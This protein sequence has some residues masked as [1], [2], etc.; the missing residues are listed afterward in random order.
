LVKKV[1]LTVLDPICPVDTEGEVGFEQLVLR[2][3]IQAKC[4]SEQRSGLASRF[5]GSYLLRASSDI[6]FRK[7]D[8][9]RVGLSFRT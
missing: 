7:Y 9:K 1:T 2:K 4:S 6:P 5:S 3:E 8:R